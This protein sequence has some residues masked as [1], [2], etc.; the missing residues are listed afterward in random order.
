[1]AKSIAK[2]KQEVRA[3]NGRSSGTRASKQSLYKTHK[4][5]RASVRFLRHHPFCVYCLAQGRTEPA[6]CT[7]HKV[8]HAGNP[9]LFWSEAN[10]QA[11]CRRCHD[12][13]TREE[14]LL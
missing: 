6:Y 4:W 3:A 8:N 7:D 2:L 5:R 10:W 13:K 9:A 12:N 1:M 11:L 14:A